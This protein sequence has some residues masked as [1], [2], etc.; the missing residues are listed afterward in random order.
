MSS[1]SYTNLLAAIEAFARIGHGF[2]I[3]AFP[4]SI[5]TRIRVRSRTPSHYGLD[6]RR[7]GPPFFFT[8]VNPTDLNTAIAAATE[9]ANDRYQRE[10][11]TP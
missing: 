2:E 6:E 10:K 5:D 3:Q 1:I 8:I 7:D 9:W 11:D 4:A